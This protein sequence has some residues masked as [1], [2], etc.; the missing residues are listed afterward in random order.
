MTATNIHRGSDRPLPSPSGKRIATL[1]IDGVGQVELE[2]PRA[3]AVNAGADI[4]ATFT[5]EI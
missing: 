4:D 1:A 3:A 5:A 2:R